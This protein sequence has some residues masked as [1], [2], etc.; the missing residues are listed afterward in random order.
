[1]RRLLGNPILKIIALVLFT[2]LTVIL[3]TNVI[4]FIKYVNLG[5]YDESGVFNYHNSELSREVYLQSVELEDD[6]ELAIIQYFQSDSEMSEYD[7][8]KNIES[9]IT[10]QFPDGTNIQFVIKDYNGKVLYSTYTKGRPQIAAIY[11]ESYDD[12]GFSYYNYGYETVYDENGNVIHDFGE[13]LMYVSDLENTDVEDS[14]Y[15]LYLDFYKGN[16]ERYSVLTSMAVSVIGMLILLCWVMASAGYSRKE[17]P[18][19][20][21][22]YDKIPLEIFLAIY[23]GLVVL[24][25]ALIIWVGEEYDALENYINNIIIPAIIIAAPLVLCFFASIANRI[26][27]NTFFKNTVIWWGLK[28]IWKILK[29]CLNKAAVIFK[30][31][32]KMFVNVPPILKTVISFGL[33]CFISVM[34]FLF[35]AVESHGYILLWIAFNLI[36]LG[37]LCWKAIILHHIK[38]GGERIYCGDY[39][40][41]IDTSI[42]FLDYKKFAEYLNSV[43]NG[44]NAAVEERMKSERMKS[45]L[46]TNVSHDLKTPLTSII[47][48]VD[49]LKSVDENSPEA[50]QYLEVLDRQSNRLKKLTEDLIFAAKASSGTEKVNLEKINIPE[51]IDQAVAEYSERLE[52]SDL[53]TVVAM[54]IPQGTVA[55][56]DGR[57]L[58]R[59]MD[60]IFGNVCKY[61]QRGTRVYVE[62][63]ETEKTV[64]ISVKNISKDQLNISADELMQRFVR[65]DS[66]RSSEGSGL[67]LSIAR[68]LA[69]LQ[70][71][72]FDITVDGDL[73]KTTVTLRKN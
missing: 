49:L 38:K 36:V 6:I 66:S 8:T 27:T 40:T 62:A 73:F 12:Y 26:K 22:F 69:V 16:A 3:W 51:F 41:K 35:I 32:S 37:Y 34:L 65:G 61:A 47:N 45:E 18:A 57:L 15:G 25:S 11:L 60:N 53:T 58:W 48:Y 42:M 63:T 59:I 17:G 4:T 56:G 44:L 28:L 55:K 7:L 9:I 50:E 19:K 68:D 24:F 5:V 23:A 67:G 64:S 21:R 2:A 29:W 70:D 52:R 46:I 14:I 54:K 20:L 33:Y 31:T 72:V 10:K 39:D 13:M 43:G 30:F 71:G 1:M